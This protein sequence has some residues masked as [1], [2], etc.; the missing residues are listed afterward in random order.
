MAGPRT[1]LFSY[2]RLCAAAAAGLAALETRIGAAAGSLAAQAA[3]IR[4][5]PAHG[6]AT[7]IAAGRVRRLE[8]IR[9]QLDAR[10]R[11]STLN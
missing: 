9:A 8:E 10:A 5:A 2:D 7:D 6:P 3:R 4:A 11:P 1:H